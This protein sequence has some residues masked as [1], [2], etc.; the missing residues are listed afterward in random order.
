VN[1][2][3]VTFPQRMKSCHYKSCY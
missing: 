3:S 2:E 1:K